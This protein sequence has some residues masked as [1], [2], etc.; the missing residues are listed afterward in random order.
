MIYFFKW[1]SLIKNIKLK[2]T[3]K[4][5]QKV[6]KKTNQTFC[7]ISQKNLKPTNA[8]K[9]RI[10][11]LQ[12][13]CCHNR[14]MFTSCGWHQHKFLI[15]KSWGVP[16]LCGG[17]VL[18]ASALPFHPSGGVIQNAGAT[19]KI[20]AFRQKYIAMEILTIVNKHENYATTRVSQTFFLVRDIS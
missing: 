1:T 18:N 2:R 16:S 20:C 8:E 3:G 9:D 6:S 19:A 13:T 5:K 10:W 15:N 14:M 12:L 7:Q 17:R 11:K 4:V